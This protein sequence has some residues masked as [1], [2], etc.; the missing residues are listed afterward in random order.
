MGY[1]STTAVKICVNEINECRE[2]AFLQFMNVKR[3][4]NKIDKTFEC[5][6]LGA[7]SKMKQ[8]TV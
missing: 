7:L 3:P 2:Y 4:I 8:T 1:E 6:V 5:V